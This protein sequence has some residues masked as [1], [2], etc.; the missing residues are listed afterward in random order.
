[1]E[2]FVKKNIILTIQSLYLECIFF[3]VLKQFSILRVLFQNFSVK[4]KTNLVMIYIFL[5]QDYLVPNPKTNFSLKSQRDAL[6]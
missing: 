6:A 1:M 4:F 2:A 5:H 3:A